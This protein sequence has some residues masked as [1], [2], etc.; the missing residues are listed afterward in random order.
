MNV[1][2]EFL[3]N[4]PL[5]LV[6]RMVHQLQHIFLQSMC[7][8]DS[9]KHHP[10]K[11]QKTSNIFSSRILLIGNSPPVKFTVH[12]TS[13]WLLHL[14]YVLYTHAPFIPLFKK[15]TYSQVLS[16]SRRFDLAMIWRGSNDICTR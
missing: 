16:T 8:A 7:N 6:L 3:I 12:D 4:T 9:S 2:S 13:I 14:F 1:S 5:I 15:I 10:K 11:T